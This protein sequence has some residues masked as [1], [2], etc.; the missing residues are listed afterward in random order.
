MR[1]GYRVSHDS[2]GIGTVIQ[3]DPIIEYRIR[4]LSTGLIVSWFGLLLAAIGAATAEDV[5]W[6]VTGT[7]LGVMF[8]TR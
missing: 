7:A 1:R 3:T 5:N 2:R 6:S 4:V 8:V